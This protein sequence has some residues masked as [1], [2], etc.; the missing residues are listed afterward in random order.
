[1]KKVKKKNPSGLIP[2]NLR[3]VRKK[4]EKLEVDVAYLLKATAILIVELY[5]LEEQCR[6][7]RGG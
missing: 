1:M 4:I 5:K 6:K 3:V 7:E 2:R